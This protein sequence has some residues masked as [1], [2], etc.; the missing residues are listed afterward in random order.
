[1]LPRCFLQSPVSSGQTL[2]AI[3]SGQGLGGYT[4]IFTHL[5]LGHD[6]D[7]NI[8]VGVPVRKL[9]Q[10]KTRADLGGCPSAF[11]R[12]AQDLKKCQ[13]RNPAG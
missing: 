12:S 1:M 4:Y 8:V 5:S 3:S 2:C 9:G 7:F 6:I 11:F 13:Y 10:Q